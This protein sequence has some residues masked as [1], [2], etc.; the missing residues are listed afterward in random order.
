MSNAVHPRAVH[1]LEK[2]PDSRPILEG[3]FKP[4]SV[5]LIGAS[6]ARQSV[7]RQLMENLQAFP[8]KVYP[9]N[10]NH[11]TVLGVKSFS[12]IGAVP[13]PVDLAV[14]ATP[15]LTVPDVV[16]ECAAAGV[17]GAIIISA[18]FRKCD[19]LGVK[20]E[21]AILVRR[22]SM[23]LVGPNC[24]GVMF[25]HRS[26]NATFA[27][28]AALPGNVAFI[29][30]S[31]ALWASILDWSLRE[32]V[33]FSAFLSIGSML[34]VG[35]GDL[36]YFLAD[37]LDTR[38][39]LICMESLADARGFLSAAREVALRTPIVVIKTGRS[40]GGAHASASHASSLTRHDD[41]L[42]AAF[43]RVGVLRADTISDLFSMA[44]VLGKQPRPKGSRLAIVTNARGPGVLA[45]DTVTS[46]GGELAEFSEMNLR[47]LDELL[48]DQWSRHNPL[49]LLGDA[50]P[51]RFAKAIETVSNDPDNDGVLVIL[52][53]Q[54]RTD[55][56]AVAK[57]LASLRMPPGKPVLASLM[58][59]D[60]VAEGEVVLKAAGIPT[61]EYPD[62]AARI[63]CRLSR[64][65]NNLQALY[66]TPALSLASSS[67]NRSR[68]EAEDVIRIVHKSNRTLLTE[69]ESKRVLSA[70][71]IPAVETYIADSEEEAAK[72][73]DGLGGPVVL[74]LYSEIVTQKAA[75]G[76][77]KL[78]LRTEEEV[79]KAYRAIE[80]SVA[81]RPGTFLG[82]AVEPMIEREGYEANPR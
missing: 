18:K 38:S 22:G 19:P 70:Y 29:S 6:E 41:V 24:L 23:R 13:Q 60:A 73:A 65:A 44:A 75:V 59:A 8:G 42:D 62:T 34:D 40:N 63:F 16:G 20:I 52:A 3:M 48:P 33:G 10:P 76:G 57:A 79:R 43:R 15:A 61:F 64:Y 78:N 25:P 17:K 82:A 54:E 2:A 4:Q 71:G 1:P 11:E 77:V 66:E 68:S 5:A 50:E 56:T 36:I 46:E 55:A 58:G 45:A 30:Q 47:M 35:W 51:D 26:L 72:I 28:T 69:V 53:P 9:V 81:D 21:E 80:A 31:G 67:T 32:K 12:R 39:I 49:D 37:D 14:I 74:K 27:K 7:G